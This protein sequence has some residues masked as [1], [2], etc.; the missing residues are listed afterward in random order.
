VQVVALGVLV[1]LA[2]PLYGAQR[3]EFGKDDVDWSAVARVIATQSEPGDAVVFVPED[4]S[5]SPR[6]ALDAYPQDFSGVDDIGGGVGRTTADSLWDHGRPVT[7]L[8]DE[9]A[10][11]GRVWVLSTGDAQSRQALDWLEDNGFVGEQVGSGPTT[12]VHLLT[13]APM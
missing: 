9:L 11:A 2:A 8:A 12:T 3:A 5:R 7:E 13:P 6:R 4:D 1:A 10:D